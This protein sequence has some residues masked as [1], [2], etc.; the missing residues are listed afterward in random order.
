L[1][2]VLWNPSKEVLVESAE[3]KPFHWRTAISYKTKD[4]IVVRGYD[5]N[6]LT[7]N[8]DF[9]SMAHLVLTGKLPSENQKPMLNA[10]LVSLCEH[11]FSPSSA[12]S[13]FVA[14]GGVPLNTAVAGGMLSMGTRHASADIPARVFQEGVARCREQ[15][16][17][18]QSCALQ[19]VREHKQSERILNGFHH[20]QHIRDPRVGRLFQL[21]DQQG[22]SGD[23]QRLALAMQEATRTVYGRL[24]YLNGPG[25]FAAIGSDMGLTPEQ[26]KGLM[27]LSRTVSLIAHTIE[28]NEREKGWRASP[29]AD[30]VQPLDLSLQLPEYYDGPEDRRL[31]EAERSD[32]GASL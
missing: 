22:T 28:E 6:E 21:S 16:I 20:P 2:I 1:A 19:I 13:R 32:P 10:L 8:I 17:D 23:H 27:I 29:K 26:I 24:F 12:A 30:I 5:N 25:A 7:G 18:V 14:S 9:A 11:A 3:K 31:A 4:R 15:G